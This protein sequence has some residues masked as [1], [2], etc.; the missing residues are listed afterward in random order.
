[1]RRGDGKF[2]PSSPLNQAVYQNAFHF[3]H[4]FQSFK[5]FKKHITLLDLK[6]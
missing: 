4:M 6:S 3:G 5:A 1:M 2:K